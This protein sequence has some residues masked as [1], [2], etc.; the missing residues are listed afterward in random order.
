MSTLRRVLS[1]WT[2]CPPQLCQI[3]LACVG[4]NTTYTVPNAYQIEAVGS[5]AILGHCAKKELSKW[6]KTHQLFLGHGGVE[7]T[8]V[9][10]IPSNFQQPIVACKRVFQG[11]IVQKINCGS[12]FGVTW[13]PNGT[14]FAYDTLENTIR[15]QK[16]DGSIVRTIDIYDEILGLTWNPEGDILAGIMDDG[17][18]V[19][20]DQYGD[21]IERLAIEGCGTCE[22]GAWSPDG[23]YFA[24]GTSHG[25]VAIGSVAIWTKDGNLIRL[26]D[27]DESSI[28]IIAW[29]PN[30]KRLACGS[31]SCIDIWTFDGD[32]I[33][34]MRFP[35]T[36]S[37]SPS[38]FDLAWSPDGSILLGIQ[39]AILYMW[40]R[41]GNLLQRWHTH[42]YRCVAWHPQGQI[43]ANSVQNTIQI[44]KRDGTLLWSSQ[45]QQGRIYDILW[46][47][48]GST[49]LSGTISDVTLWK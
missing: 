2:H 39:N 18:V 19:F 30:G 7:I 41:N 31:E 43:F 47:P 9:A 38:C 8:D 33:R 23:K 21:C 28:D 12:L 5:G 4:V 25:S 26:W 20:W 44:R 34:S 37:L 22:C 48:D 24:V 40:D 35:C 13:H 16:T 11:T 1:V 46:S 15:F 27:T 36:N 42:N 10:D 45:Q 3:L 29:D 6:L 49:L 14:M 32:F 17:Y